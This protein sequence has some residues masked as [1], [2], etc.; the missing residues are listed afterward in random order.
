MHKTGGGYEVFRKYVNDDLDTERT[1]LHL[2]DDTKTVAIIDTLTVEG[3]DAISEP[4]PEV[5]YQYDN[6]LGSACLELNYQ[7]KI[8]SYEEYHPFGTTSYRSG[9]SEVDV[10]LKRYKYVGKERNE[11]TGLYPVLCGT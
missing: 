3:G 7:G 9:R 11:E 6:H 2:M 4:E 5:R 8:I 10:A 1:T